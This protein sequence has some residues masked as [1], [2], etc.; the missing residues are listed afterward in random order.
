MSESSSAMALE[1]QIILYQQKIVG[2]D[3]IVD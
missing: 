2:S 3:E 1:G